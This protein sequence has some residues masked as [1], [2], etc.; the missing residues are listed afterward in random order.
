MTNHIW[1]V[2]AYEL[3]RNL[4][5]KGFLFT[6]FGIPILAYIL[7][8]G[9]QFI[10]SRSTGG[11]DIA[12]TITESEQFQ[13]IEKAGYVDHSGLFTDP[14]DLRSV[15]SPYNNE[16]SAQQA[17]DA[18]E[19]DIYYVFPENY[20]DTGDVVAYMP[21][22]S[23]A[24]ATESLVQQLVYA[25][26]AR[27]VDP[28]LMSRLI[29][30]AAINEVNLQR[31]ATGETTTNFDVDFPV[32]Y[33]FVMIMMI[34]QFTTNGYLMQTIIEEKET[35]LIEILVSALRPTQLLTGK[36]LA[37]GVLGLVQIAVWLGAVLLL[38]RIAGDVGTTLLFLLNISI[39]TGTVILFLVYFVLGYLFFAAAYGMVGAISNSMQEG[40]QFAVVFVLPAVIPLYF[41]TIFITQPDGTLATALSLFPV[42]APLSMI[43][44]LTISTVPA[45]QVILS[46]VLLILTN[47]GMMWLAG[48]LFRVNTLLSGQTPKL[49]DIPKLLRG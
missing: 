47:I 44:R 8:F 37:L 38:A 41:M 10:S 4:R 49:R 24:Q 18:G 39:P 7:F 13:G 20:L 15:L 48:R 46:I 36:I 12:T 6:T 3:Q 2:F 1:Q 14:G 33:L 35:K 11:E 32:I 19:I 27:N 22:F 30:P 28:I 31:D 23:I 40:P 25:H 26:F 42:T 21:R 43:M 45:W 9:Y 5:R 16:E 29:S 34:S 17:M